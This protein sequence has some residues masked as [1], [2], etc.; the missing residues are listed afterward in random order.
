MR[1]F[2]IDD[3][4]LGSFENWKNEWGNLNNIKLEINLTDLL[5]KTRKLVLKL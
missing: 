1:L 2:K 5:K 4:N 3:Q